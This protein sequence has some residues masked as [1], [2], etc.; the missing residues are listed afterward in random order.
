MSAKFNNI[1]R[2][3]D[4]GRNSPVPSDAAAE[5]LARGLLD[6]SCFAI[7]YR[8]CL[9]GNR[10]HVWKTATVEEAVACSMQALRGA[11][12][13]DS[14]SDGSYSGPMTVERVNS[15]GEI[16]HRWTLLASEGIAHGNIGA[17]LRLTYRMG[18]N[19]EALRYI[20]RP[21]RSYRRRYNR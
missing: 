7:Q 19:E 13:V 20:R 21:R 12:D 4:D 6:A 5:A 1:P 11:I 14:N 9:G 3:W 18:R 2:N 15:Q 17:S 10:R 8:N 16:T